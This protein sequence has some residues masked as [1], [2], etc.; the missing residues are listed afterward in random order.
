M[1]WY[2]V[3]YCK[4]TCLQNHIYQLHIQQLS[5]LAAF[6]W[7]LSS[8]QAFSS[9][10]PLVSDPCV[11]LKALSV[12]SLWSLLCSSV[13]RPVFFAERGVVS[14][15]KSVECSC[16]FLVSSSIKSLRSSG[17]LTLCTI[18]RCLLSANWEVKQRP[19]CW[20]WGAS[21]SVLCWGM[22]SWNWAWSSELKP[23]LAQR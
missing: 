14:S 19:Q 8:V 23:H 22:C 15:L 3:F 5:W 12:S 4:A 21:L 16:P 10:D 13:D 11:L 18:M 7:V 20:H 9:S 6:H 2:I 1:T 17:S